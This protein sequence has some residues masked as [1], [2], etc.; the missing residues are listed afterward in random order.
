MQP[1]PINLSHDERAI[2]QSARKELDG[3]W[4]CKQCNETF[5]DTVRLATHLL[6]SCD[7]PLSTFSTNSAIKI[8]MFLDQ[9]GS[10]EMFESYLRISNEDADDKGSDH[11]SDMDTEE[12]GDTDSEASARGVT[13]SE[14]EEDELM[15]EGDAGTEPWWIEEEEGEEDDGLGSAGEEEESTELEDDQATLTAQH[16][17]RRRRRAPGRGIGPPKNQVFP[18][19]PPQS[20]SADKRR[21]WTFRRDRKYQH[22]LSLP[23]HPQ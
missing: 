23:Y 11:D 22:I 13:L 2:A 12:T 6:T 16:V 21:E 7:Q 8:C 18:A 19:A 17:N 4:S 14:E 9:S 3:Q 1:H 15:E 20:L 5:N 10:H